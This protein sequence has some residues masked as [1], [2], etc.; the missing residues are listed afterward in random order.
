MGHTGV[1]GPGVTL[2]PVTPTH[3]DVVYAAGF[4]DGEGSVGIYAVSMTYQMRISI[5]QSQPEVI[6]WFKDRWGGSINTPRAANGR[7][8]Y[9]L[10]IGQ[11][12]S[13]ILLAAIQPFVIVKR[14][15]VDFALKALQPYDEDDMT[16]LK[17]LKRVYV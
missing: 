13:L 16:E 1:K 14:T 3:D 8:H 2:P 4:F 17:R 5:S 11:A 15:Q 7:I 6:T 10:S 12:Q 9:H